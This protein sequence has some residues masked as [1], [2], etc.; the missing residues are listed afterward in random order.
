MS[1]ELINLAL[2]V[3]APNV[4]LL[5]CIAINEIVE[6]RAETKRQCVSR[7]RV[8]QKNWRRSEGAKEYVQRGGA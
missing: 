8:M 7:P 4:A 3:A 5:A 1:R 6:R 2:V